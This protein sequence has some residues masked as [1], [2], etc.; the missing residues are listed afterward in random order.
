MDES[1]LCVRSRV[2]GRLLTEVALVVVG[3][4]IVLL[5]AV[6]LNRR[7]LNQELDRRLVPAEKA[8]A[9]VRPILDEIEN[10]E[11]SIK[12][13]QE[14][15]HQLTSDDRLNELSKRQ[16]GVDRSLEA[17]KQ[18]LK[19]VSDRLG[20]LETTL[21]GIENR[22]ADQRERLDRMAS[23]ANGPGEQIRNDLD[24]LGNRIRGLEAK[25]QESQELTR[26]VRRLLQATHADGD[27]TDQ[28]RELGSRL[29]DLE[30]RLNSR[31]VTVE[32]RITS[33]ERKVD[34]ME[35]RVIQIESQPSRP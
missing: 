11:S 8:L 34:S 6:G 29:K 32:G 1:H 22:L 9:D 15:S 25:A 4:T 23:V 27:V 17:L 13:L 10:L 19:P 31:L 26:E 21:A 7:F 5:V 20:Q 16:A 33:V 24:E 28:L 30:S 3:M 18:S 2:A 12:Q 14:A 35:R